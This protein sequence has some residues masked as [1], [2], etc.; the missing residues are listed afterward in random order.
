[1]TTDQ[2]Q[3]PTFS[4]QGQGQTGGTQGQP[5]G[6]Q[7]SSAAQTPFSTTITLP[8]HQLVID[9]QHFLRML[10][11]SLSLSLAEKK[12]I[13]ESIPKLSQYQ[14]DKLLEILDEEV[15]KFQE[16][17][18]KYADQVQKLRQKQEADWQ[19]LEMEVQKTTKAQLDQQKAD[20]IR[21]KLGL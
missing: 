6:Q 12:R 8:A 3:D 4:Q 14:V 7:G 18:E 10:A 15:I 21:K 1:M 17:E 9:E 20:E 5:Q 16:L 19:M 13:V 2:G 11:G